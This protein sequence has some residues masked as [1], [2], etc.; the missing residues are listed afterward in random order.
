MEQVMEL[1]ENASQRTHG[2]EDLLAGGVSDAADLDRD[3][4]GKCQSLSMAIT[5]SG[6]PGFTF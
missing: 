5:F 2:L 4:N 1:A 3:E 6:V